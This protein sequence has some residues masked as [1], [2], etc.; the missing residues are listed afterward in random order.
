MRRRFQL[1]LACAVLTACSSG[2]KQVRKPVVEEKID[3]CWAEQGCAAATMV[4]VTPGS[5]PCT[6]TN[7]CALSVFPKATCETSNCPEGELCVNEQNCLE[8]LGACMDDDQCAS[9][10]FM[11]YVKPGADGHCVRRRCQVSGECEGYCVEGWCFDE[12]GFCS[13]ASV[14]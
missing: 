14:L 6:I 4:C 2:A 1:A 7:G 12:P 5:P 10:D 11:C 3:G 8:S 13:D 9:R